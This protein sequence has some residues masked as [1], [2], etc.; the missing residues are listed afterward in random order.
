MSKAKFIE[1]NFM[2]QSLERY[3]NYVTEYIW[4]VPVDKTQIL[5]L[6]QPPAVM[7]Y[8]WQTFLGMTGPERDHN[9]RT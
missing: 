1:G 7:L 5:Y 4:R 6:Q 8:L 3:M 2:R 9:I